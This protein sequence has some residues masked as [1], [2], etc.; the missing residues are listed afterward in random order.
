[1]S[2]VI[3]A[4]AWSPAPDY[5]VAAS[6]YGQH[7][8]A[9]L[10]KDGKK[11]LVAGGADAKSVSLRQSAVFDLDAGT[12]ST[13]VQLVTGRQLHA[14]A[15]LPSG[16]VLVTGGITAPNAAA[17]A[18]AEIYD[19][20][21]NTWTATTTP[22]PSGRWGHSAVTLS[23]GQVLIS[24]GSA[25]RSSGTVMALRT[26][27]LF[28]ETADGGTWAEAAPMTDARTGHAAVV[29]QDGKKVLVCGGTTPVGA[30][31]D[32]ALAFCEVYDTDAKTWKP[33]GSMRVPRSAHTATALSATTV[34]VAGGRAPGASG[35][36]FDPF[37]RDT[38]EVFDLGAAGGSWQLTG[39]MPAGRAHHRAVSLGGGKVLVVGGTD[40]GADE[41]GYRGAIEYAAGAWTKAPGLTEGRWAFAA[42]SSGAKVIVAGG[43][44]RTGLAAA[45]ED[46]EL[47]KKAERSGS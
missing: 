30:A 17:L 6:W 31:D 41:A 34:L 21:Q 37:A 36:S 4:A 45:S 15:L 14:L 33:T 29:L 23:N 20:V 47:T 42:A 18:T 8:A 10:L 7:D 43:V 11:V 2:S 12:W 40:D 13:S 16:K 22:M 38:A 46:V 27:V 5:A 25:I 39:V 44:A 28:T 9:I 32:P 3:L 19:P 24:G 26:A 1:M 35:G